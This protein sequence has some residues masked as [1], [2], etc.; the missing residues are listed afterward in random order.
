MKRPILIVDDN[1]ADRC[2]TC[3]MLERS[4]RWGP[5]HGIASAEEALTMFEEYEATRAASP[6]SFPPALIL[7]DINM[8]RMNGFEFLEAYQRLAA[9]GRDA[10][11]AVVIV[12]LSS[13]ESETDIDRAKRYPV[14]RGFETKP[15]SVQRASQLA[16]EVL[17]LETKRPHERQA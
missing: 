13:S 11:S 3:L 5:V 2:Y 9:S 4:G 14:V 10:A 15:I 12:M 7:L 8:P 1:E 6:G 16:E 17:A